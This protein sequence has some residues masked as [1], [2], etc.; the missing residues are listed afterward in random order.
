MAIKEKLAP[1]WGKIIFHSN[2]S[3]TEANT[4]KLEEWKLCKISVMLQLQISISIFLI[5]SILF[6]KEGS[7]RFKQSILF[8][9]DVCL[10]NECNNFENVLEWLMCLSGFSVVA[11]H[12]WLN[13]YSSCLI[14][15]LYIHCWKLRTMMISMV[16]PGLGF[17]L[18]SLSFVYLFLV[19]LV[20]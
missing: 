15:T 1:V 6:M 13:V 19:L 16:L 4:W 11:L 7:M 17:S 2:E 5:W 12:S 9:S 18:V 3:R 14:K 20:S 8:D 10:K